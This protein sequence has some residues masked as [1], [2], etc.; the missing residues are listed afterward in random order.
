MEQ[1]GNSRE[2]TPA[3]TA[4]PVDAND[5]RIGLKAVCDVSNDPSSLLRSLYAGQAPRSSKILISHMSNVERGPIKGQN[6]SGSSSG[7]TYGCI[8][9]PVP[10][11]LAVW[12]TEGI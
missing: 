2:T 1:Q 8:L 11:G 10:E 5:G 7:P 4:A 12:S 6:W 9:L 3:S